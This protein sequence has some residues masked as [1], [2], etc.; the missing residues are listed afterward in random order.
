MMFCV[1]GPI[2]KCVQ[3]L[4]IILEE[5]CKTK[6]SNFWAKLLIE[7]NMGGFDVR[8]DH[9]GLRLAVKMS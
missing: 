1:P 7:K 8:V 3:F 5:L 4:C 6:V 2:H 9:T